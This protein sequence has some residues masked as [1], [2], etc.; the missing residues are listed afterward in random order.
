MG[1]DL[2]GEDHGR[3]VGAL[4]PLQAKGLGCSFRVER[5]PW[6]LA[7]VAF[8]VPPQILPACIP[9]LFFGPLVA[10]SP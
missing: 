4:P 8:P 6:A 9:M 3:Q 1:A 7:S 2:V 10:L 5:G